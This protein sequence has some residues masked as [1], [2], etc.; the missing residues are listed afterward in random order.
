MKKYIGSF[1]L[2]ALCS[3]PLCARTQN[4]KAGQTQTSSVRLDSAAMT[5][6]LHALEERKA[7]LMRKVAAE[8]A[9]RNAQ[10]S[11]ASTHS[12]EAM[13]NRQDSLC[14]ALRSQ[15]VDVN[16][17]IGE[18]RPSEVSSSTLQQVMNNTNHTPNK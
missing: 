12:L 5:I 6:K 14:L 1:L 7:E 16:L 2:L 11:G 8:D 17:E 15:L 10:I 4:Q 13:N 9:R 3:V 18:L